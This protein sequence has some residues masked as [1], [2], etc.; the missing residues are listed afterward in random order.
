MHR[1]I[2]EAD[3]LRKKRG[4]TYD[5]LA[6]C[7]GKD[8]AAVQRQFSDT[9]NPTVSTMGDYEDVLGG[10]LHFIEKEICN[11]LDT[12]SL[13]ELR[14]KALTQHDRIVQLERELELQR[15]LA[16]RR[17][18]HCEDLDA[19]IDALN[20]QINEKDAQITMMIKHITK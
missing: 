10:E 13:E 18:R 16:D 17:L 8:R 2:F 19:Q 3:E 12:G 9:A 4:L 1:V 7:V 20:Q 11:I 6:S 15:D 5:R 14:I